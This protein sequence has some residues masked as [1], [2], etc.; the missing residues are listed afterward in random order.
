MILIQKFTWKT[1]KA[2][3]FVL[4]CQFELN[5]FFFRKE[6]KKDFVWLSDISSHMGTEMKIG[7]V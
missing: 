4:G 6:R 2:D 7:H 3:R 5:I 1:L